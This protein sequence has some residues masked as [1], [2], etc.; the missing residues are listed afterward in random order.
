[1]EEQS[2]ITKITPRE[3]EQLVKDYLEEAGQGLKKLEVTHDTKL[4]GSDGTYQIDV[5][6]TFE[7]FG[8]SEFKVLAECKYYNKRVQRDH[9]MLLKSR[10]QSLGAHKGLL[11]SN[12]GFQKGASQF[13]EAHGIALISVIEGRFTYK[14]KSQDTPDFDPPAWADIPKYVGEYHYGFTGTSHMIC[15][16]QKERM[17]VLHD[18][19]FDKSE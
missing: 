5:L 17:D 3:F 1:M 4:S 12:A 8:G 15:Y 19:I 11:F 7:A 2:R 18:F 13:A 9:V 16:L 6:A 14:T 10:L